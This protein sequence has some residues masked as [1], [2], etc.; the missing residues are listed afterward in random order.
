VADRES[1]R[2]AEFRD[3]DFE[4]IRRHNVMRHRELEILCRKESLPYPAT[5]PRGID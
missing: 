5:V 3:A 2:I 4:F 1:Q